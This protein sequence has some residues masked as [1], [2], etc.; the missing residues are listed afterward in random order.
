MLNLQN[1][2]LLLFTQI[3]LPTMSS[4]S[5]ILLLIVQSLQMTTEA[6][7]PNKDVRWHNSRIKVAHNLQPSVT[8]HVICHDLK[9]SVVV[10][11]AAAASETLNQGIHYIPISQSWIS[12]SECVWAGNWI[13]SCLIHMQSKR[14]RNNAGSSRTREEMTFVDYYLPRLQPAQH[15][16]KMEI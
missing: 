16:C 4:I 15:C 2:W 1:V 5:L 6:R 9:M 3:D 11:T 12:P 14:L 7:S 10:A 13:F 8:R